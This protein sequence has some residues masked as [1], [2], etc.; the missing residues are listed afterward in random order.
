MEFAMMQQALSSVRHAASQGDCRLLYFDE[1][2]FCASPPVQ[3]SWSPL[4]EPHRTEPARHCKRS[5]LGALDLGAQQL[6]HAAYTT[7]INREIVIDFLDTVIRQGKPDQITFVVLDNARIHHHIDQDILDR[8]LR[9][10]S[11]ML[12]YLP[13]YSPELNL[14]EIVWNKLKY[15]WRRFVTWSRET[16]DQEL[17]KLLGGYGAEFQ[18]G[19][20]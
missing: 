3:R 10:H 9:E 17:G 14:I 1:A 15:H 12:I 7:T 11:T 6:H 2:T 20:L 16:F 5:V 19:F 4:G 18:V 13:P 8:W